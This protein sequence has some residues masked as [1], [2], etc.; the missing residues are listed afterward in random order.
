[1]ALSSTL[2]LLQVLLKLTMPYPQLL[3][4]NREPRIYRIYL[5]P[6]QELH[7]SSVLIGCSHG[8]I[9]F[10]LQSSIHLDQNFYQKDILIT[11]C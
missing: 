5:P 1:M 2:F 11:N 3:T 8:M 9:I 10:L 7:K 6:I 4:T